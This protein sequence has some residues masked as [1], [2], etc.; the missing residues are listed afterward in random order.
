MKNCLKFEEIVKLYES[1][2]Y[3]YYSSI[4][5]TTKSLFCNKIL[6][7]VSFYD[8]PYPSLLSTSLLKLVS[9]LRWSLDKSRTAWCKWCNSLFMSSANLTV[10]R[11]G[12][13]RRRETGDAT[14]YSL[15]L[16]DNHT[17][18]PYN[19]KTN[20]DNYS[21]NSRYSQEI[22]MVIQEIWT[23]IQEIQIVIQEI[24]IVIQEIQ[25]VI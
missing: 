15:S 25:I 3:N 19:Q 7:Y 23:V 20:P 12:L 16:C 4:D 18:N 1:D 24:W 5:R 10:D 13:R 14:S 21:R 2:L 17:K 6:T 9:K 22:K 11:L 8:Y